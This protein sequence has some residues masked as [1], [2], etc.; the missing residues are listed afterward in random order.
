M[1]LDFDLEGDSLE[2][3]TP[4][5]DG[6]KLKAISALVDEWDKHQALILRAETA[7]YRAKEQVAQIEK[8]RLPAAMA[9]AGVT[10]F[11][12]ASGRAI[13]IETVA[14]GNIPALSTVEKA[15]GSLRVALQERRD[16]ALTYVRTYWPG[17]VKTEVSL[18]LGR[19]EA[20]M[21][22]RIAE[23]IR[24]E[25]KLTPEVAETIHPSTLNAHFKEINQQ[26]KI[27]EVPAELFALYVGPIAKIK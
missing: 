21:A 24:K 9:E 17:L 26:G 6:E 3:A 4:I 27:G 16:R 18:A 12:T 8:E 10:S 11:K 20:E 2:Q 22:S 23:F 19:G 7:L 13:A 15:K 5:A 1:S 25:F 14:N